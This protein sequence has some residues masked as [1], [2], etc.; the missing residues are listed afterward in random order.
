MKRTLPIILTIIIALLL[1]SGCSAE[2]QE[3]AT[4]VPREPARVDAPEPVRPEP[5]PDIPT[6]YGDDRYFDRLW[7]KCA[8]DDLTACEDLFWESPVGSEYEAYGLDR[9]GELENALTDRDI[10][11]AVGVDFILDLAWNELT[12]REQNDLCDGARTFGFDVAGNILSNGS[13][14]LF[15]GREAADWL[16]GK[17][18]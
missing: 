7:D 11:D 16:R 2:Y 10:V 14:G 9:I 4:T 5:E 3:A 18:R 8:D 15:T 17:C 1:L 6:K 13:D 12:R